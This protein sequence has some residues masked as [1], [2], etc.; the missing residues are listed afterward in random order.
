MKGQLIIISSPSGG[1]KDSVI[2]GLVKLLPGSIKFVTTTTR[3]MRPGEENGVDYHFVAKDEFKKMIQNNELIEFNIYSDNYY[4]TEKKRM[5]D[6]LDEHTIVFSNIEING[7]KNFDR[8]GW[9]NLSIFLMPESLETLKQRIVAR[10]G[11][12]DDKIA[13]R[14]ETAKDEIAQSDIYDYKLTNY[15]GKLDETIEK[16]AEIIRKH[17][18]LDKKRE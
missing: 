17:L 12:T 8:A 18:G 15:Q 7:K 2:R 4:G 16:T 13:T 9:E 14:L 11:L 6:L 3:P 5:T 1:G 10:G